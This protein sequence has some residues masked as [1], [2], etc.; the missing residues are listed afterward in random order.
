MYVL[1]ED[2]YRAVCGNLELLYYKVDL[3][4]TKYIISFVLYILQW[5]AALFLLFF[6]WLDLC[7][8]T[9][10]FLHLVNI[11]YVNAVAYR[12]SNYQEEKC[13]LVCQINYL[14][15]VSLWRRK[16]IFAPHVE[17]QVLLFF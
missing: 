14:C 1:N 16:S 17:I 15:L 9:G 5:N 7:V 2:D 6:K 12:V 11:C 4:I 10:G 8:R 3:W 13:I